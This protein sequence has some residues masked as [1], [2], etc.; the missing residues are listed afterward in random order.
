MLASLLALAPNVGAH[1]FDV[2]AHGIV[3]A[4][5]FDTRLFDS[6]RTGPVT[7]CRGHLAYAPGALDCY[8]F[9]DQVC[10]V[11][12]HSPTPTLTETRV[13]VAPYLFACPDGPE[14]PLC[15]RLGWRGRWHRGD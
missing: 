5:W 11:L 12:L 1:Q 15:P 3:T 14:P 4:C 10:S 8:Q 13:P 2:P 6:L 7:Y 9:T